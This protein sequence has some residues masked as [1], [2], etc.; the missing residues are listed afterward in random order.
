MNSNLYNRK[1]KLP[2]TLLKHLDDCF[3]SVN[4]DSSVEGYNRNKELRNA[5]VV[6]YQQLK[7]IK[8]WFDKYNGNGKDVPYILNGGDRMNKWCNHVLNQWRGGI[9]K[10]K[11]LKSDSGM[12]NQYIKQHQKTGIDVRNSANHG[13]DT[14][15]NINITEAIKKINKLMKN[16]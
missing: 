16:I 1:A 4:G 14:D 11:K 3:K 2:D 12:A 8:N 5:G 9:E 6:T 15:Y 13:N 10:S 7:R